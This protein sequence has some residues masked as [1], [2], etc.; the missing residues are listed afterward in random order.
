[1]PCNYGGRLGR[2]L[3]VH[4]NVQCE[5][6]GTYQVQIVSYLEGDPEY[7][8]RHCKFKFSLPYK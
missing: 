7:K 6:C 5:K 1:M 3:K 8:C 4:P 2:I